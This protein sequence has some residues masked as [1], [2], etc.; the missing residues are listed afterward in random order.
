[1]VKGMTAEKNIQ[2]LLM[3]Y[4][5]Q[6]RLYQSM[7]DLAGDLQKL[8]RD[9]DFRDF[10]NIHLLEQYLEARHLQ[11]QGIEDS[12]QRSK[13]ILAGL[14]EEAGC[15]EISCSSLAKLHPSPETTRLEELL[16]ALEPLLQEIAALDGES[17]KYLNHKLGGLKK[18]ALH[19]RKGRQASRAYRSPRAGRQEGVFLDGKKF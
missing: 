6:L 14:K 4:E 15:Q 11:M 18:E 17:Q 9:G 3:E 12:R 1:M 5:T 10:E 7:R 2:C 16:A 19:L 8:S 13:E